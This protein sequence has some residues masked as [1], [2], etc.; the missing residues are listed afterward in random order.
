MGVGFDMRFKIL[1]ILS[2]FLI[3]SFFFSLGKA[4]DHPIPDRDKQYLINLA[5]QT[6]YWYLKDGTIPQPDNDSLSVSIRQKRGCFVTLYKRN[7]GLRGCVGVFAKER[8]LYENVIDR[9]IAAATRDTRFPKVTLEELKDIKIEITVLSE[10]RD[11]LFT[12]PEDLLAKLRPLKDGVILTT[13]YGQSTYIPQVWKNI[14]DKEKFM[15]TLCQKHGAPWDTWKNDYKNIKVLTY[16]AIYFGE[17]MYG[18]RVIGKNGAVVG[19]KGAYILGA[20]K[21][22]QEGLNY[23]GYKVG[24]GIE[25]APGA[26]V[27]SDSDIFEK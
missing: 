18:R 13:R 12:S 3:T 1:V 7:Y 26:I 25:L 16:Q 19:K 17:E 23:G 10:P 8:S 11:L 4:Q 14:P 27:T 24:E 22:L 9:A 2:S 5:R 15:S 6:L 20:V 21:P